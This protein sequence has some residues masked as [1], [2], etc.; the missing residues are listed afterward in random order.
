MPDLTRITVN[1]T[2][3]AAA[4]LD[5]A[6]ARADMTKTDTINRALILLDVVENLQEAGELTIQGRDGQTYRIYLL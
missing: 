4:A 3:R 6:A 5:R 1:L 2:P